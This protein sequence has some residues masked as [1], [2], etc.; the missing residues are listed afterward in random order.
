MSRARIRAIAIVAADAA[1]FSDLESHETRMADKLIITNPK[2]TRS[3]NG[4]AAWYPYYAGFSYDFAY[5]LIDSAELADG[6]VV[7]D[8]W[9]GSGTTTAAAAALN[10]HSYGFDLNPVMVVVAKARLLSTREYPSM[11]PLCTEIIQQAKADTAES[12]VDDPL[13][14]WFVK[15]AANEVRK[16]ERGIQHLLVDHDHYEAPATRPDFDGMSGIGAFLYLA[17]FRTVRTL[18]KDFV[19]TNPTWVKT[20]R[21]PYARVRPTAETIF[22]A[23]RSE[24]VSMVD[25]EE[26]DLFERQQGETNIRL[27]SSESL[28]L[29]DESIRLAVGSPPYCTRIDYAVATKPELAVLG[30]TEESIRVLRE[31][32]MGTST[33]PKIAPDE[34]EQ[35][36][37]TCLRFLHRVKS[38]NSHASDTY[39]YKNHVQYFRSLHQSVTEIR[40][41]MTRDAQ[42]VLVI[43]D[44]YYKDIRNDLAQVVTEMGSAHDLKVTQR[45]DFSHSQ[46]MAAL[47]PWSR[48]YRKAFTAIESVLV[49]ERA[50]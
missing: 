39:Y 33:V 17:L 2:R 45:E 28:P 43:Q 26:P 19:P 34:Q 31:R 46:T 32:L 24:V 6:A 14:L 49:F 5:K 13:H 29:P 7:M 15:N 38:H 36:G 4:R 37:P 48:S 10:H 1:V 23:F 25:V 20:P 47:N 16:I 50:A 40:R 12:K 18:L 21:S 42:S 41:V 30:Y 11:E 3:Q 22:R 44:S 35:W 9:N 27:N 8:D